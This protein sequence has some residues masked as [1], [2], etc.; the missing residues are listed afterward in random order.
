M[1][2]PTK[3]IFTA[4]AVITL[5]ATLSGCD[6]QEGPAEQAGKKMDNAMDSA[7]QKIENAGD[8]IQDAARGTGK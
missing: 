3:A 2:T 6:K 8:R 4:L 7:G 1:K 5:L